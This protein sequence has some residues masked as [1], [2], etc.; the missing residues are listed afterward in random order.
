[1]AYLGVNS[2]WEPFL[3]DMGGVVIRA[4]SEAVLSFEMSSDMFNHIHKI[5]DRSMQSN[6]YTMLIDCPDRE[7]LGCLG[8]DHFVF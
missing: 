4:A 6:M 1:M 3:D 8:Q 2:T 7:K 5:I